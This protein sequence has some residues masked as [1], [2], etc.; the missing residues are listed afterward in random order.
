MRCGITMD[1]VK[2]FMDI[3]DG[4]GSSAQNNTVIANAGYAIHSMNESKSLES[5]ME[6]SV[7][8]LLSGKARKAF[9]NLIESQ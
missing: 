8:S 7:D 2:I 3:L 4:R 9:I 6:R 5:C 1:Y